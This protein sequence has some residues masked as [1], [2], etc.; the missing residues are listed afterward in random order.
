MKHSDDNTGE[1]AAWESIRK[2]LRD[3]PGAPEGVGE[4]LNRRVQTA[5]VACGGERAPV[6]LAWL[7]FGCIAAAAMLAFSGL[8][9][10]FRPPAPEDFL[11][12]VLSARANDPR[13]AV[14]SFAAP[15]GRGSVVW[16]EGG[17]FIPAGDSVR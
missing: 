12:Q 3:L 4:F 16:V 6:W 7:G 15:T 8:P 1:G 2:R 10:V 9:Q 13:L 5:I 14:T 11:S 17:E